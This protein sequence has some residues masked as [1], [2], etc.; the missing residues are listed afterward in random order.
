MKVNNYVAFSNRA[1]AYLKLKEYGKA[2][3]DCSCALSI[4]P[5]HVKSLLRRANA[6][7]AIGNTNINSKYHY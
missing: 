2:E 6:K 3:K 4:E 7:N 5:T 1:M